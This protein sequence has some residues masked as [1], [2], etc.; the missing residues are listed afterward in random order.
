[1]LIT[2]TLITYPPVIC[3]FDRI[4]KQ[5]D[6]QFSHALNSDFLTTSVVPENTDISPGFLGDQHSRLGDD[7]ERNLKFD[8]DGNPMVTVDPLEIE[9]QN[10]L[11][12][13]HDE[14]YH[15]DFPGT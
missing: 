2:N 3:K 9:V 4:T 11:L 13:E 10:S 15:H 6:N 1:M 12:T 5:G 8:S 7:P 14:R